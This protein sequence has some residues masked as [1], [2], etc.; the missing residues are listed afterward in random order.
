MKRS[1]L[2]VC[3]FSSS[4]YAGQLVQWQDSTGP[5][6]PPDG[7]DF[8][9]VAC[10]DTHRL[11]LRSNGK[12]EAWGA[13]NRGQCDVPDG[14]YVVIS[15]GRE[16][17]LAIRN[18]GALVAWGDPVWNDVVTLVPDGN[19]YISIAT[20]DD[21]AV[22]LREDGS[23]I[24]WGVGC[25]ELYDIPTDSNFVG[26][27]GQSDH[28]LALRNDGTVVQWG[29]PSYC[30]D[31]N[32]P[33]YSDFAF[34]AAGETHKLGIRSDGALLSWCNGGGTGEVPDGNYLDVAGGSRWTLAIRDDGSL[35]AWG[36]N[37]YGQCDVPGGTG[38]VAVAGYGQF[39]LGLTSEET[40]T[41]TIQ[42][43]PA[44]LVGVSPEAGRHEYY[45][46][47][48]VHVRT[49]RATNCPAVY[50][51]HH[52]SGD[53]PDPCEPSQLVNMDADK[54]ITA[55]YV[56]DEKVCGDECHPVQDGDING[57]CRINLVDWAIF[58]GRYLD[59]THPD[60]D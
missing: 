50:D 56:A 53:I 8:V 38:F 45:L 36:S 27:A 18:D 6:T 16:F 1:I 47:K 43:E 12:I 42:T 14:N 41:L 23:L 60:C 40:A 39:A 3:L 57:D 7:N 49:G 4:I 37:S 11:A 46:G 17:S 5:N 15:A 19:D 24:R 21:H 2:L 54:T 32:V 13:N 35:E 9:E 10:G 55:H 25:H 30:E 34:I 31:P 26:I 33:D 29:K 48:I 28:Y 58:A 20:G 59:C 52:W 51:F 22:A 44:G